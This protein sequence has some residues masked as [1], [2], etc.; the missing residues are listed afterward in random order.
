LGKRIGNDSDTSRMRD[1]GEGGPFSI[2]ETHRFRHPSRRWH[3]PFLFDDCVRVA[4]HSPLVC[5]TRRANQETKT[6]LWSRL[7]RV[8]RES[9]EF[10][11]RTKSGDQLVDDQ[12]ARRTLQS[13]S[14][15]ERLGH[16]DGCRSAL[17][18]EGGVQGQH[19]TCSHVCQSPLDRRGPLQIQNAHQSG[20][21]MAPGK[22]AALDLKSTWQRPAVSFAIADRMA[23][24][25]ASLWG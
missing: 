15:P 20:F 9:F 12:P 3:P 11:L 7:H 24:C 19:P 18:R 5:I 17:I 10:H 25:I 16:Y 14:S 8:V 4:A 2:L 1:S 23:R 22:R 6:A 21:S 13:A